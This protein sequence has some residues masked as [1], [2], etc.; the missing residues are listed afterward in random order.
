MRALALALL[1]AAPLALSAAPADCDPAPLDRCG[2]FDGETVLFCYNYVAGR[3]V[4][5]TDPHVITL[6]LD[7]A[8]LDGQATGDVYVRRAPL[9]G[10]AAQPFDSDLPTHVLWLEGNVAPGLQPIASLCG[11]VHWST[12]CLC[13]IGPVLPRAHGPDTPLA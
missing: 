2:A 10:F 13:W 3:L 11:Y 7:G 9:E 12:G 8:S 1:L 6:G 4:P 5:A